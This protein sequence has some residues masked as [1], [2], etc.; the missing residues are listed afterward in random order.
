[1]SKLET[2]HFLVGPNTAEEFEVVIAQGKSL[3]FKALSKASDLLPTGEREVFFEV[4][5]QLGLALI[6]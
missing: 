4:N 2:R 3:H 6:N 1:M 5:G